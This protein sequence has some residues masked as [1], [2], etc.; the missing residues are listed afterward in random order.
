MVLTQKNSFVLLL[1][2]FL[3]IYYLIIACFVSDMKTFKCLAALPLILELVVFAT[4][5]PYSNYLR[6]KLERQAFKEPP[7][8]V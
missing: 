6:R 8:D 4:P 5:I 1:I 3:V 2:I 7:E